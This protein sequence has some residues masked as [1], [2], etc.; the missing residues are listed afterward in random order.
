MIIK[1]RY[2]LFIIGSLLIIGMGTGC[3]RNI[4]SIKDTKGLIEEETVTPE[5]QTSKDITGVEEKLSLDEPS[6]R[7]KIG[8]ENLAGVA[9]K[10][11][12]ISFLDVYFDFDKSIIREDSKSALEKNARLLTSNPD[13]KVQI[14]GHCDERGTNEYNLAL[15]QRRAQAT[16]RYLKAIGVSKD[17]ISIISYGEERPVCNEHNEDCWWQN[18]HAHIRVVE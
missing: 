2:V 16:M 3:P 7:E 9:D 13:I 10:N 18:R 17:R 4:S 8:E 6:Q 14:E 5:P 12:E 15:G 1:K 11:K